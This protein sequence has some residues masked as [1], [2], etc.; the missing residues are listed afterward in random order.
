M[1]SMALPLD[2]ICQ[3]LLVKRYNLEQESGVCLVTHSRKSS[4]PP[5]CQ[6]LLLFPLQGVQPQRVLFH[7]LFHVVFFLVTRTHHHVDTP[8]EADEP[9][10]PA[11]FIGGVVALQAIQTNVA[12]LRSSLQTVQSHKYRQ[13]CNAGQITYENCPVIPWMMVLCV[14]QWGPTRTQ[15]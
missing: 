12:I 11:W 7:V 3:E 15:V 4:V 13:H 2:S 8:F 14:Q 9:Q 1:Y 6:F 10:I 5:F